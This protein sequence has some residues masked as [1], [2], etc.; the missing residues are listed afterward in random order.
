MKKR[1][2]FVLAIMMGITAGTIGATT[3]DS[4]AKTITVAQDASQVTYGT[5]TAEQKEIIATL[6][7]ADYYAYTNYDV[8]EALGTDYDALFNHF[9]DCGI[10]EGRKGWPDFD[11]SAYASAYPQLR[12]A[13]G[14][15]ILAYYLDYYN[16][17]I[18]EGRYLTTVE[19]CEENGIQVQS[20]FGEWQFLDLNIYQAASYLSSSS[21]SNGGGGA[22]VVNTEDG[23]TAVVVNAEDT[24]TIALLE[25]CKG[26][27]YAGTVKVVYDYF[28]I[29]IAKTEPGYD[30]YREIDTNNY[31]YASEIN[32]QSSKFV[33]LDS[34][35]AKDANGNLDPSKVVANYKDSELIT[36]GAAINDFDNYPVSSF[37]ASDEEIV[38]ATGD[39]LD[40][41][42]TGIVLFHD[43]SYPRTDFDIE[44]KPVESTSTYA[45][46]VTKYESQSFLMHTINNRFGFIQDPLYNGDSEYTVGVSISED[47]NGVVDFTIGAY[48]EENEF[49]AT[50]GLTIQE[51]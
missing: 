12:E 13:Y 26:L 45:D 39:G 42:G 40:A 44:Y 43:D 33:F 41:V 7:D 37:V 3:I 32:P 50:T 4:E 22:V 21:G 51:N 38:S 47:E 48:N 2:L 16:T 6:F 36:C 20:L 34:T 8:V 18:A 31:N 49:A 24:E 19:K 14:T 10:W 30:V 28:Y 35:Y 25:K 5:L 15:N 11:P 9:C 23:N 1:N 29:L 17:G 27:N 46:V